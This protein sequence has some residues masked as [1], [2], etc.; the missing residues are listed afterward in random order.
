MSANPL[1]TRT[2]L[3]IPQSLVLFAVALGVIGL[4][5]GM[6]WLSYQCASDSEDLRRDTLRL[7]DQR[8]FWNHLRFR[9]FLAPVGI[10]HQLNDVCNTSSAVCG[11][12]LIIVWNRGS[13]RFAP[14]TIDRINLHTGQVTSVP[15]PP[16]V[17]SVLSDGHRTWYLPKAALLLNGRPTKFETEFTR[18][19]TSVRLVEFVDGA[20]RPSDKYL[21]APYDHNLTFEVD[22]ATGELNGFIGLE[23]EMVLF[24][25]GI[26]V[27]PER[28]HTQRLNSF[29]EIDDHEQ[30]HDMEKIPEERLRAIGWSRCRHPAGLNTQIGH[31]VEQQGVSILGF[32]SDALGNI[33]TGFEV[34]RF[35]QEGP[36]E[37]VR[38]PSPLRILRNGLDRNIRLVTSGDGQVYL[39]LQSTFDA[40]W[41]VLR[42]N[43]GHFDKVVDQRSPLLW[44]ACID[45]GLFFGM[46]IAVPTLLLGFL[47]HLIQRRRSLVMP[48]GVESVVLASV[49]RRGLARMID[50]LLCLLP[51]TLSVVLHPEV[52]EWWN[53]VVD[54]NSVFLPHYF[55]EFLNVISNPTVPQ[56]SR[57]LRN[58]QSLMFENFRVPI[59]WS[60]A[61][62]SIFVVVGQAIW[63]GYSGR[64]AGKWVLG[65][66]V[67]RTTG[68]RC[69]WAR[70][71]LRE[72]LLALD[73]LFLLTWVPGVICILATE[74]SQRLGDLLAGTIVVRDTH[75]VRAAT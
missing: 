5:V 25:F 37:T 48:I 13:A 42:W 11:D 75:K 2:R 23:S 33:G 57:V 19:G 72:I 30:L 70:S 9:D 60:L 32:D 10:D 53:D 31:W 24:R 66:R 26:D 44:P 50:L 3:R 62:P 64:S 4:Q 49:G 28:E 16:E 7:P 40:R 6:P 61:S 59:L 41:T 29:V 12:E 68:K 74:Q 17:E 18:R 52:I 34:Y 8:G 55:G 43:N 35:T 36:L 67:I 69:G 20:W 39:V 22:V 58:I 56:V 54:T 63:Q 51:L 14:A 73:S 47:A 71:L 15:K 45:A 1:S 27:E 65:M 38:V 46:S 21:I